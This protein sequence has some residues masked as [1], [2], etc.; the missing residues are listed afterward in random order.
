M[1][2]TKKLISLLLAVVLIMAFPATA[3]A[4]ETDT[5]ADACIGGHYIQDHDTYCVQISNIDLPKL[6]TL[7]LEVA[8]AFPDDECIYLAQ[9]CF[10]SEYNIQC[11]A[12]KTDSGAVICTL[13][14]QISNYSNDITSSTP[15]TIDAEFT[16]CGFMVYF[17]GDA[18]FLEV[19]KESKEAIIKTYISHDMDVVQIGTSLV[20]QTNFEGLDEPVVDE[21]VVD[22]P[23]T[24][25]PIADEPVADEPVADEPVADE[26]VADEPATDE[27]VADE[28]VADEPVADEPVADTPVVDTNAAVDT[29]KDNPDTGAGGIAAVAA[30]GITAVG[31]ALLSKK[32][33]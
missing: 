26:P 19:L 16:D 14:G 21:P 3:M 10:S 31:A 27:P 23:V 4:L 15:Y 29:G 12:N 30:I 33:K 17:D 8:A 1:N 13:D 7:F 25:E 11:W 32:K 18:D 9:C 20:I 24:D 5:Y 28:P 22:E 6:M 2:R